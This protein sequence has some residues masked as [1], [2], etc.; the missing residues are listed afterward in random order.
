MLGI[1][2]TLKIMTD[3]LSTQCIEFLYDICELLLLINIRAYCFSDPSN[4]CPHN[5]HGSRGSAWRCD[6]PPSASSLY[7]SL[8]LSLNPRDNTR[9]IS[10][11]LSCCWR[12][13]ASHHIKLLEL[14]NEETTAKKPTTPPVPNHR[15]ILLLSLLALFFEPTSFTDVSASPLTTAT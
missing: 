13:S 3:V 5:N 6:A 2:L 11:R 12:K 1:S 9:R 4:Y 8:L 14:V 10:L 7:S 15:F